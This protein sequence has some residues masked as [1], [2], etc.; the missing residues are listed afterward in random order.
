[1]ENFKAKFDN[2]LIN[3]LSINQEDIKP[4]AHFTNDLGADSLD[5]VELTVEFEKAFKISIVDEDA[6]HLLTIGDAE[7]YLRNKLNYE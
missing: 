3:T 4:K 5:F 7:K 6:E 2:L 1:M